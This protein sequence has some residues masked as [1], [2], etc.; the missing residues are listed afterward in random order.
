MGCSGS[1]PDGSATYSAGAVTL[2]VP[3][4]S[5]PREFIGAHDDMAN[6]VSAGCEAGEWLSGA[7]DKLIAL[8]D[9]RA[10]RVVHTWR[11]HERGVNRVVAAPHVGGALSC[12]RD[13]TVRLWKKGEEAPVKTLRGHDLSVSAIAIAPDGK[14]ALSGSRDSSLRLW[15]LESGTSVTRCHLSRNVVTCL[16]WVEDEPNLVAQGSEDLRLRIWD[17]RALSQPAG[18]MEGYIYFPLCVATHSHYILTGSNGFEANVGCELR[19][20]DRRKLSQVHEMSGHEQAV[21][22]VALLPSGG[23]GGN[24]PLLA[25]SG[26]KD[27]EVRLWGDLAAAQPQTTAQMRL[28]PGSGVTGLAAAK[29]E[30][31]EGVKLYASTTSGHCHAIS[32]AASGDDLHLVATG[33]AA[34]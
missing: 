28:P 9:W 23:G 25:A 31:A 8:S 7:E 19:L 17:V 20:W 10:G 18:L 6:C 21:S 24:G 33:V 2:N 29:A 11:G 30:E 13:T 27:G 15:D 5:G 32:A 1:K 34:Q 14:L 3:S 22:G 16:S 4:N 12:S 26:C